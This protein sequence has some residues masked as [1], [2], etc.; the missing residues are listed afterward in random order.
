M[1]KHFLLTQLLPLSGQMLIPNNSN[2]QN[3][4]QRKYWWPYSR[5]KFSKIL[6]A[7][8]LNV[9]LLCHSD[10]VL[11]DEPA[12]ILLQ[13][14]QNASRTLNYNMAFVT[15]NAQ[16]GVES[17]RFRHAYIGK[18]SIAQFLQM[19]G[20]GRE[21]IQRGDEISYFD[22]DLQPF[23]LPG[24]HIVSS[25]PSLVYTNFKQLA[26]YYDFITIGRA[27]I[28]N[29][30]CDV[31]RIVSRDGDRY[32]YIVW[33]DTQT[34]LPLRIDLLDN[35]GDP[36][37][38]FRVIAYSTSQQPDATMEKLQTLKLPPLL[39]IP[40]ATKQQFSWQVNWL[41]TGFQQISSN[42]HQLDGINYPVES[43]LYSD[44]LFSFSLHVSRADNTSI[45]QVLRIGQRTILSQ[46]SHHQDITLVGE[47][48]PS[49]AKRI[50]GSVKFV[51]RPPV[52]TQ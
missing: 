2:P 41:P 37:E 23:T 18:Q 26:D 12:K 9:T 47:L 34:S 15:I 13:K 32:S 42:R 21:V 43:R 31:V 22:P 44:G 45:N 30:L 10:S 20:P 24:N 7:V 52:G 5:L 6:L 49:V 46:I 27:R 11:A 51:T 14:M 25:L 48:P 38:Q 36:L 4:H 28:A 3:D 1:K 8:M 16:Q 29:S 39:A 50:V 40:V 35:N 33:L 17:L 19:D